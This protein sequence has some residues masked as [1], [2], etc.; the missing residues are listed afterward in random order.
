MYRNLLCVLSILVFYSVSLSQ[1]TS[2]CEGGIV[3]CD[4]FYS[5]ETSPVG[6]GDVY[7]PAPA[8]GCNGTSGEVNSIWYIFT[9]QEDGNLSFFL[10]PN[11]DGT[12]YDWS[13]FN[14]SQNGC[15]GIADGTSPEVSCNSWGVLG[16]NGATGIST[17]NGGTGNSNGPGDLN[18]PPFNGDLLVTAGE[19]FALIVMNWTGSNAGYTLDFGSSTASLYDQVPPS[20]LNVQANCANTELILTFS[21]NIV[22]S[23]VQNGD[24][25]ISGPGGDYTIT[26]FEPTNGGIEMDNMITISLGSQI[27]NA[28]SYTIEIID[29]NNYVTD[30]CGNE[31]SGTYT[32]NVN[33]PMVFEVSTE[34]ACNG[35]GGT[36]T[37]DDV[38]G[39]SA[40]FIYTING[41][42]QNDPEFDDLGGGN[43]NVGVTDQNGC[44]LIQQVSVPN[45]AISVNAG[46]PDSLSCL[47]PTTNLGP[48]LVSPDQPVNFVWT[49][50]DGSIVSGAG[51]ETA[52]AGST[53]TY[54][55]IVTNT[56]N[57]CSDTDVVT[58][59]SA[60]EFVLDLN[61]M[62][63]PNVFSPNL[64]SWNSDW[65]PFLALDPEFDL[66]SIFVKYDLKVFNRWGAMVYESAGGKRRWRAE[67]ADEGTYFYTLQYESQCGSGTAGNKEGY[68]QVLR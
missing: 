64:D 25:V 58:V 62:V 44:S 15:A 27:T 65:A 10:D 37:V 7:E 33:A 3:L 68:I 20:I 31:G 45:Q 53:G 14:I 56:E 46:V 43:Y 12:D 13:L 36:I 67:D 4:S 35:Q 47:K 39:G 42:Q 6:S 51:S 1:T 18:G 26:D 21:E 9:V 34:T 54:Q 29:V 8:F 40:P 48:A 32:F 19:T 17:D 30:L 23:T 5:E 50:T 63:F 22:L 66:T 55:V 11:D 41:I 57:G 16:I 49:T 60:D 59:V 2:D 38:N 52:T 24:F 61:Q 28:G